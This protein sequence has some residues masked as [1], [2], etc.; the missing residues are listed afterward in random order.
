M[1]F[2]RNMS[3]IQKR[4]R[5]RR[6]VDESDAN[7]QPKKDIIGKMNYQSASGVNLSS[8]GLLVSSFHNLQLRQVQSFESFEAKSIR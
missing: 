2:G 3:G 4:E 1:D 8:E 6:D 5:W 7:I